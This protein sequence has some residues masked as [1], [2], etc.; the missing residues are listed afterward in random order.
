MMSVLENHVTGY[1]S[2]TRHSDTHIDDKKRRA[3]DID[4][5]VFVC[6]VNETG[7]VERVWAG[8]SETVRFTKL[9]ATKRDSGFCRYRDSAGERSCHIV[10]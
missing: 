3:R 2:V 4:T 8:S 5:R 9:R 1:Q 7:A 6:R 10:G